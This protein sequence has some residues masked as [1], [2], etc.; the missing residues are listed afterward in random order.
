MFPLTQLHFRVLATCFIFS[1][2]STNVFAYPDNDVTEMSL[3]IQSNNMYFKFPGT[4]DQTKISTIELTWWQ[5]FTG[6]IEGGLNISYVELSQKD[7]SSVPAYDAS[8]YEVGIGFR[9]KFIQT[10]TV[11]VGL[12]MSI[13]YMALSGQTNSNK[14]V[15]V[16]WVKYSGGADF[17]FFPSSSISALA[18]VSY[19]SIDGE[20]KVIDT[21]NSLVS[22]SEDK[23]EGYYAGVSFKS[24]R[25][26]KINMTWHGGYRSGV[27]LT[28][29]N[30]F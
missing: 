21:T 8:G 3:L 6:S 17:E 2:A 28:F 23:P 22:F 14:D 10:E 15:E 1:V 9:S 18:G 20:N 16:S 19:T 27:Y 24:G 26:G 13:D 7:N 5:V 11:N 29:S 12:R 4:V 25:S 30:Q